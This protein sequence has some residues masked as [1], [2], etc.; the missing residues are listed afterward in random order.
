MNRT[1]QAEDTLASMFPVS[2]A[3]CAAIDR[4][5]AAERQNAYD[6]LTPEMQAAYREFRA[7]P[8]PQPMD[9]GNAEWR[10]WLR[11]RTWWGDRGL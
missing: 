11:E 10:K 8:E 6:R 4:R 9:Y 3:A 5:R 1:Q 2:T 7:K